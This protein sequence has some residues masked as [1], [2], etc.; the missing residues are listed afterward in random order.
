MILGIYIK[1]IL[2]DSL[3][4]RIMSQ[5]HKSKGR[6]GGSYWKLSSF[7]PSLGAAGQTKQAAELLLTFSTFPGSEANLLPTLRF[8]RGTKGIAPNYFS[9]FWSIYGTHNCWSLGL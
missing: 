4:L 1:S 6:E 2:P 8:P 3:Y 9:L 7:L 5:I